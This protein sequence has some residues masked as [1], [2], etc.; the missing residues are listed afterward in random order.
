MTRL[1]HVMTRHW[2]YLRA[3]MLVIGAIERSDGALGSLVN[4]IMG[5]SVSGGL[6]F[7][8][9]WPWD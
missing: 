3:S 7:R 8:V 9:K 1:G 5:L 4:G 2:E 6:G